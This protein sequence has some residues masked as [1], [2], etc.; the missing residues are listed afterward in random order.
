MDHTGM[1]KKSAQVCDAARKA[2]CKVIHV[3][4]TLAADASDNPNQYLGILK[5]CKDKVLFI[6]D[7]WNADFVSGMKPQEG[8]LI[9]K[10]KKGLDS[11]PG[12]D[13]QELLEKNGVKTIVLGGFLTSCCVESS[14]RHAYEL[15]YNV[16]TLTDCTADTSLDAYKAAVDGT[17]K[18]FSTPMTS[19]QFKRDVLP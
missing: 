1:L 17:F 8:D 16:I 14:M 9:V 19:D 18:L 4:I 2:G 7:T 11:F 12:S 3:P 15:G 5:A 13:L 10:N 6:S